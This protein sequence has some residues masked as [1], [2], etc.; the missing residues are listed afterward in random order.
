MDETE[1]QWKRREN[2]EKWKEGNKNFS[3]MSLPGLYSDQ[4]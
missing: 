4:T 2:E 1:K 3:A